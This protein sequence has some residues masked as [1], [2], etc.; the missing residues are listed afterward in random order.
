MV[1]TLWS[2]PHRADPGPCGVI[3]YLA[4]ALEALEK[5]GLQREWVEAT[6]MHPDWQEA[7][8][9]YPE[10]TRSYRVI[11]ALDGR[12]L[13]VIHWRDGDDIVVL[14]AYPDR[15]ALKRRTEP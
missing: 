3:L 4:H 5:R 1:S 12:I 7:D 10:R 9:A 8:P 13:R 11:E 6:I 15:D 2:L 14:T